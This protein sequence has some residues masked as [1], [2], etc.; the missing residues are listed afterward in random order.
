MAYKIIVADPSP[1]VQKA[2]QMA[3]PEPEFLLFPFE[4]GQELLDAVPE[5]R[6]DAVLL[7]PYLAGRD[8]GEVGRLLRLREDFAR[9][10]L[11]L[12]KGTFESL[13]LG[14]M[15]ASD[16]DEIVQKP[17]DSERLA[18]ALRELIGKKACPST[19][20]EDPGPLR[21]AEPTGG[22]ASPASP[23]PPALPPEDPPSFPAGPPGSGPA[24]LR[25]WVKKEIV[26]AEREIEKRVRARVTADLK[27]WVAAGMKGSKG[28]P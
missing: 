17:F 8:G 4:N 5:I 2:L 23:E 18:A 9:V 6:P 22:L 27:E 15:A 10:P 21:F 1:S 28:N 16:Y 11:V 3:F 12:L 14:R 25:E 24:G 26:G 19:L 7:S 13:D 20:P